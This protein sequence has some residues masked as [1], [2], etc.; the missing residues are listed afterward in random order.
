[1][2]GLFKAPTNSH[3]RLEK[4]I[5]STAY[6]YKMKEQGKG[7][8]E[9]FNLSPC[10]VLGFPTVFNVNCS[11]GVKVKGR[12]REKTIAILSLIPVFV[13][14]LMTRRR[15]GFCTLDVSGLTAHAPN[16]SGALKFLARSRSVPST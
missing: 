8:V 7:S 9:S 15:G 11:H 1:M 16:S 3:T 2:S 13:L 5:S 12:K 6:A 4:G 14:P 10:A